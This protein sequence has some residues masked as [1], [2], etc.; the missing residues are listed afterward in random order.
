MLSTL[1]FILPVLVSFTGMSSILVRRTSLISIQLLHTFPTA[2][3]QQST[4]ATFLSAHSSADTVLQYPSESSLT[5]FTDSWRTQCKGYC[6]GESMHY[7]LSVNATKVACTFL[8][9]SMRFML[10]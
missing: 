10:M 8:Q 6:A 9:Q 4:Y 3:M 2:N 1:L 5:Q 7:G